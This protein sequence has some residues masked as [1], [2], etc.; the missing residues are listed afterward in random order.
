MTS[1]ASLEELLL[2]SRCT[3][4]QACTELAK[5][6]GVRRT[7]VG[8]LCVREDVLK[9][10]YPVEL[11]AAGCIPLSGPAIAAKTAVTKTAELYNRFVQVPH[12]TVFES[13]K[14]GT[15]ESKGDDSARIQK[16][17]SAPILGRQDEVL[18]VIQIS[19]K[20]PT[21]GAAGAD[22]LPEDLKKLEHIARRVAI[23]M[24]E[25]LLADAKAPRRKLGF[26]K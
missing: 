14:L 7:E 9:F 22:F 16:L 13:I 4:E 20:G 24:P 10:L 3:L 8:L 23:L 26:S 5:I 19:R 25:I 18:G 17:M 6:F 11:Q 15:S 12:H 21:P 2:E 1:L